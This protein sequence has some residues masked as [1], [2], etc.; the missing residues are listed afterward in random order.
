VPEDQL[1]QLTRPF[2]R[3]DEARKV[4]AGLGPGPGHSG[5]GGAARWLLL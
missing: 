4:S 1:R 3:V 5:G 2:F